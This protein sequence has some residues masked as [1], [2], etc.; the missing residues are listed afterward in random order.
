VQGFVT[1]DEGEIVVFKDNPRREALVELLGDICVD[2]G[3]KCIVWANFKASYELIRG[4]CK[5]VGIEWAEIHGEIKDKYKEEQRF[6]KEKKCKVVIANQAA[7]G[8]GINLVE[9]PYTIYYG[10]GYSYGD[11][12]QSESRNHRGGS[13]IHKSIFRVDIVAGSTIDE[14]ALEAIRN[15]ETISEKILDWRYL[16]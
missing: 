3:D 2:G 6:K 11:D 8:L 1:T 9:A 13:E 5:E 14:L 16:L 7:A 15:K 12:E 10:R 4:V